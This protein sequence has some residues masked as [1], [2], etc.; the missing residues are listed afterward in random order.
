MIEKNALA[1]VNA[2]ALLGTIPALCREVD[3][4]RELI[5]NEKISLGFKVKGGKKYRNEAMA[6]RALETADQVKE[7]L[8]T[9]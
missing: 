9:L 1:Y 6:N 7:I 8:A 3:E 4:A 5:K 2:F